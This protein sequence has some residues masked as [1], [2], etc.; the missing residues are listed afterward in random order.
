M[1]KIVISFIL[2]VSLPLAAIAGEMPNSFGTGGDGEM[3]KHHGHKMEMMTKELGLS[4][5]QK[6]KFDAIFEEQRAKFHAIHEE[7]KNRLQAVLTPEQLK[8]FEEMRPPHQMPPP[9]PPKPE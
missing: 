9:P 3:K 1:K 7:T 6:V 8:K 5:E 4:A 2:A